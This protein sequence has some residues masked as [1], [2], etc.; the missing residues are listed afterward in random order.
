MDR[1]HAGGLSRR[2]LI[3]GTAA[4]SAFAVLSAGGA[5]SAGEAG[6]DT[7]PPD[8]AT[9]LSKALEDDRPTVLA[10]EHL[11][12]LSALTAHE[13]HVLRT[14]QRQDRAHARALEA[15]MTAR[16]VALAPPPSGLSAVDQALSAKGMSGGLA[17][18]TTLKQ[19]VTLLLDIEAL[20]L[21][22]Y[23]MIIRDA[24]DAALAQRAAQAM[25]NDAQHS[26]L[27]TELVAPGKITETVP[28]WYVTGVT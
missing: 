26:T 2:E 1:D 28:N 4:A 27:L 22:G 24:S 17:D 6:A 18:A 21:G 11:V 15:Q 13:R 14:L 12:P 8:D 7:P 23:Y 9:L 10:Y 25:G 16:G 20:A 19:A 5:L 3:T